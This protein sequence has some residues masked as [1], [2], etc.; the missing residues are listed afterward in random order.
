MRV[1]PTLPKALKSSGPFLAGGKFDYGVNLRGLADECMLQ[2]CKHLSKDWPLAFLQV[3]CDP[4]FAPNHLSDIKKFLIYA[5]L[6]VFEDSNGAIVMCFD[7]GKAVAEGNPVH[8][9]TCV[10][11]LKYYC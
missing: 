2:M 1:E 8:N 9:Y 7:K 10:R 5:C 4:P 3:G 6:K 11:L